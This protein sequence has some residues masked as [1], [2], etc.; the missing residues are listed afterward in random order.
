MKI[1]ISAAASWAIGV[2]IMALAASVELINGRKIRES[3]VSPAS[4]QA[5]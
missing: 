5:T 4:G 1:R 2:A 3:A